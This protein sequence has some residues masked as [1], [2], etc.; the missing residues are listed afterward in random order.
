MAASKSPVAEK[1]MARLPWA[2]MSLSVSFEPEARKAAQPS[3]TSL[4][5]PLP[6]KQGFFSTLAADPAEGVDPAEEVAGAGGS[7]GVITGA[8]GASLGA[9][10]SADTGVAKPAASAN[11]AAMIAARDAT[12]LLLSTCITSSIDIGIL[13]NLALLKLH[14]GP[15]SI[16]LPVIK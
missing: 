7:A 11:V 12:A 15:S 3:S 16:E 9:G 13:R 5:E 4:I 10:S 6:V 14:L 1:P 2:A 8:F